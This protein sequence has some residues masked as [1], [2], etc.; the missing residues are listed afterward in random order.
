[1]D[2]V[3]TET[4]SVKA[5]KGDISVEREAILGAE[6]PDY[7]ISHDGQTMLIIG[8]HRARILMELLKKLAPPASE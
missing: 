2:M 1:M 3:I 5:E 6:F 8:D 7:Y 4:I